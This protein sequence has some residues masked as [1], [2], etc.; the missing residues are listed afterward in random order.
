MKRIL[1]T[2]GAGFLGSHLCDRLIKDGHDVLC[3]DNFFTGSKTNIAHQIGHPYFELMRHDVTFPLYVEVDR[4]FNL[5]LTLVLVPVL[6]VHVVAAIFLTWVVHQWV[7][8]GDTSQIMTFFAIATVSNLGMIYVTPPYISLIGRGDLRFIFRS[9]TIL[10]VINMTASLAFIPLF[11]LLGAVLGLLCATAY[12]V[13][14]IY[15][16]HERLVGASGGLP[17]VIRGRAG[18]YLFVALLF[19]AAI[20][21]GAGRTVNYYAATTILLSIAFILRNEPLVGMLF[22]RMRGSK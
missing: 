22:A 6:A 9:Q 13:V 14:V 3:V 12:N 7:L 18:R 19:A 2:G 4:I 10:A 15:R 8:I 21:I 11:G 5:V 17:P 1:I 16:R 20:L